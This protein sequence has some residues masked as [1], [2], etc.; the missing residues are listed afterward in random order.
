RI[1]GKER[2]ICNHPGCGYRGKKAESSARGELLGAV[3]PG[4]ELQVIFI[5]VTVGKAGSDS[6]QLVGQ[7]FIYPVALLLIQQQSRQRMFA[8]GT[9][10]IYI[11]LEICKCIIESSAGNA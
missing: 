6:E 10:V 9:A 3:I 7:L 1:A 11:P 4:V 5:I 2:F 8:K